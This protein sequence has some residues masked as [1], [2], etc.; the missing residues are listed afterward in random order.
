MTNNIRDLENALEGLMK[1]Y[2]SAEE[3]IQSLIGENK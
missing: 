1:D 3:K 2:K